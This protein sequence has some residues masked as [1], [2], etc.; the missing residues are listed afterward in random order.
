MALSNR[1]RIDRMFQAM[2][3][4]LDDFISSVIG[5]DDPALG[6]EWTKLVQAKDVKNGVP[7]TRPTIRLIPQVQFRMLT[8]GNITGGFKPGWYP[9]NQA[10]GRPG[11]SLRSSCARSATS[12]RITASDIHR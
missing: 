1:D 8:E 7:A 6:A 5:Q 10:L 3:P 12:G 4:A 9:F 2:A 11:E